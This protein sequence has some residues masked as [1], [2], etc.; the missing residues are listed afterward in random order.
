MYRNPDYEPGID[1]DYPA[2][3]AFY[4]YVGWSIALL[5][6]GAVW[7]G[8]IKLGMLLYHLF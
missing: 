4:R 8:I 1:Y 2:K 7:Y 3:R 5:F 6:S